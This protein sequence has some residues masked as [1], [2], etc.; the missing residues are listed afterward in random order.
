M[1]LPPWFA[2][3]SREWPTGKFML[4]T[5]PGTWAAYHVGLGGLSFISRG[6][7]GAL[8][9]PI[10][11]SHCGLRHLRAIAWSSSQG[12]INEENPDRAGNQRAIGASSCRPQGGTFASVLVPLRRA[13]RSN[14]VRPGG[15][16]GLRTSKHGSV[17]ASRHRPLEGSIPCHGPA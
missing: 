7:L 5:P 3:R 13:A 1:V 10:F 15:V 8:V 2:R 17:K 11:H 12:S 9:A 6:C 4:S 14:F 16:T